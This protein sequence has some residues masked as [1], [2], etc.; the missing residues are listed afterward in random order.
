MIRRTVLLAALLPAA[1]CGEQEPADSRPKPVL[2]IA[3]PPPEPE[4]P[5]RAGEAEM[6]PVRI[7]TEAGDILVALDVRHAPVT[8]TNFLRYVDS[9]RL[10]GTTFYRAARRPQTRSQGFVQGGVRHNLRVVFGAIEHEPTSRTGLRHVDGAISMAR[11]APGTAMADFF[12]TVG[13]APSM[14]AGP[15]DDPGFAVFGRVTDGMDVARRILAAPTVSETSRSPRGQAI[16]RP[17]RILS[18]RREE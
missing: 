2:N 5:P 12:I 17:I 6:V 3:Q 11:D 8:A 10:D 1:G 15:D 14:D 7:V 4:R 13:A 16:M 18:V 9:G